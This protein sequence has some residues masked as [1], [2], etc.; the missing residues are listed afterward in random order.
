MKNPLIIM[1]TMYHKNSFHLGKL[2]KK[3]EGDAE[4]VLIK[5]TK[6]I[7]RVRK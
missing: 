4:P 5:K 7:F 3:A 6:T 2:R 1:K